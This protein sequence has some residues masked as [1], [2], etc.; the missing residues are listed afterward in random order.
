MPINAHPEYLEAEREFLNAYTTEEKIEKL[1]KMISVAPAHKG[2]ENLRSQLRSRLK[3]LKQEQEKE[4]SKKKGRSVGIKKE[5]DAQLTILGFTKSGKSSL[6]TALTNAKP[7]ISEFPFTTIRPEIGT[8]DLDGI[9]IQMIELPAYL[10]NKEILSIARSSNLILILVTSIEELAKMS[11]LIKNERIENKKLFILNKVEAL[12]QDELKK[13]FKLP[14]IRISVKENAGLYDLRQKIFESI[15]LI[16]VYTK[17]PGKKPHLE[18][19]LILKKD[20]T[21]R[22]MAEK[23]RKDFPE[24]FIKAKIWGSSAKFPGQT[25]GIEHV[26]H[27]KDIVE[28]YIR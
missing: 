19:P 6:L 18:R 21:V 4:K 8:L 2:S 25:V 5:G 26:L 28:M 20:S 1:K 16:R 15:G 7:K 3:K 24:R 23:I 27:D 9:K 14:I 10:E 13:F 17:E 22:D 12:N 11:E